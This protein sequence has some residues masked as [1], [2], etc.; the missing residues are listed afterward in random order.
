VRDGQQLGKLAD[1]MPFVATQ[2]LVGIGDPPEVLDQRDLLLQ[3]AFAVGMLG[4]VVGMGKA[5][6]EC[7]DL[8]QP[9]VAV[10]ITATLASTLRD[11][12]GT[13]SLAKESIHSIINVNKYS[14]YMVSDYCRFV[15][16]ASDQKR[17]KP[18]LHSKSAYARSLYLIDA[19]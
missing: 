12:L 18:E 17:D 19:I 16:E 9:V 14:I 3:A 1:Q 13:I 5:V 11:C 8:V 2:G 7:L 15:A 4:L 10:L 6:E